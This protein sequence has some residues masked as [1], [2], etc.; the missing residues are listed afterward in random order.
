MKFSFIFL[1]CWRNPNIQ[2]SEKAQAT[3]QGFFGINGWFSMKK[4]EVLVEP[5][6][7][8]NAEKRKKEEGYGSVF[9]FA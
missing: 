8:Q 2:N 7:A 9:L 4:N 5:T 6:A 1:L 3:I